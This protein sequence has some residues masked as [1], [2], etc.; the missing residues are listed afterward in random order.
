MLGFPKYF[1]RVTHL[2]IP[3]VRVLYP[4]DNRANIYDMRMQTL[5]TGF[6]IIVIS[7]LFPTTIVEYKYSVYL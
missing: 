3:A 5:Y 1:L 2:Y 6:L 4:S 7:T